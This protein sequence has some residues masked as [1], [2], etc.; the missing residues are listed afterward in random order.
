MYVWMYVCMY[1]CLYIIISN[2]SSKNIKDTDANFKRKTPK[3]WV[4]KSQGE[5]C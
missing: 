2:V 1:V 4:R 3:S 5:D